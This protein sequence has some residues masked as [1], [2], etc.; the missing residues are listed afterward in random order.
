MSPDDRITPG[1]LNYGKTKAAVLLAH[2]NNW[3]IEEAALHTGRPKN[4]LW[5]C[6]YRLRLPFR[7]LK[8][9][10]A[11]GA[12]KIAIIQGQERGMTYAEV[13]AE[14]GIK[15]KSLYQAAKT[16]QIYLKKSKHTK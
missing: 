6:G 2:Q 11:W 16:F 8:P 15:R 14:F 1:R 12:V 10:A 13:S 7:K 9:R 5:Y 4:S 3:T